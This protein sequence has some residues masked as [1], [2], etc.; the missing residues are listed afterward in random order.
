MLLT[1]FVRGLAQVNSQFVI[2]ARLANLDA[3][4]V[5]YLS[6]SDGDGLKTDSTQAEKGIFTFKGDTRQ[7]VKAR[8]WT[9]YR[10][11]TNENKISADELLFYLEPGHFNIT[12]DRELSTA[13]V[14]GMQ[15]QKANNALNQ[16]LVPFDADLKLLWDDR[17]TVEKAIPR[18]E[19]KL[20]AIRSRIT[21]VSLER[22]SAMTAFIKSHPD[23][24][25]SLDI[26]DDRSYL[27]E[28][29]SEFDNCFRRLSDRLKNT[30]LGK[31]LAAQIHT[32]KKTMP[33]QASIN[34]AQ[35]NPSDTL[36]SLASLK[37]K[38]VLIDFWASWCGPC[39]EDNPQLLRNYNQYKNKNFEIY[40]VSLDGKKEPWMQAI[41][42]DKLPWIH[43]SELNG[44]KNTAA[45]D[46]SIRAVP[47][48]VL[49]DP[50][51]TI[52][53]KNLDGEALDKK[54][55]SMLNP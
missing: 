19:K 21:I 29:L 48:N 35:K 44:W 22:H 6:Y 17:R 37:G 26:L 28:D 27:I 23:A 47:Q 33:G 18:D 25:V 7:P 3:G 8:I 9:S 51:G 14:I 13:I 52:I 31:R 55:S 54:L 5:I 11:K 2:K 40:A 46:Y 38:Y 12:G 15:E 1:V 45:A 42:E 36:I 34:I 30:P 43:V 4:S 50:S 41:A 20:E 49:I 16:A 10:D 53:A 32:E 24:L 39:R